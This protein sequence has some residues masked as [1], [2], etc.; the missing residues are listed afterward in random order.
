MK[1]CLYLVLL[2][3]AYPRYDSTH[4]RFGAL[5]LNP[6]C[7]VYDGHDYKPGQNLKRR[8]KDCATGLP[9]RA[10]ASPVAEADKTGKAGGCAHDRASVSAA[11]IAELVLEVLVYSFSA[12]QVM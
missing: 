4:V 9:L 8:L 5:I 12:D 7:P 6:N 11:N 10:C 2:T 1:R 3:H